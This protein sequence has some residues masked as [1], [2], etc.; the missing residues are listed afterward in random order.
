MVLWIYT[1]R[2]YKK[3]GAKSIVFRPFFFLLKRKQKGM[4]GTNREKEGFAHLSRV[5]L[6]HLKDPFRRED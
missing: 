6:F 5:P 2:R 1:E 3:K 4:N